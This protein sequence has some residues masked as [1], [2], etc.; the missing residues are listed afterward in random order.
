MDRR[1]ERTQEAVPQPMGGQPPGA[2][3][4][5]QFDRL[6]APELPDEEDDLLVR[7]V[8]SLEEPAE[9]AD[10]LLQVLNMHAYE[11]VPYWDRT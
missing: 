10:S 4:Q 11:W 1:V 7:E 5:E 2:N 6:L 8:L 3:P 9:A